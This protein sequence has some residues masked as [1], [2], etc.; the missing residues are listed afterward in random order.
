MIRIH[1]SRILGE[2]R[3]TQAQLARKTGIRPSTIC[4][5]YNEFVDRISLE[6]LDRICEALECDLSDLLEYI[7]NEEK[8]TGKNLLVEY[9]GNQKKPPL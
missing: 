5:L 3:W 8:R 2:K 9:H 4:E 6:Q 7:P 1:L